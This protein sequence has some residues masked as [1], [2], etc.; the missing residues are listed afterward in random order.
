M[1]MQESARRSHWTACRSRSKLRR[2][3]VLS[4][5][6]RIAI[7]GALILLWLAMLLLGGPGSAADLAVLHAF[8]LPALIPAA[9][10]MTRLGDWDIILPVGLAAA[11]IS[12]LRAAPMRGAVLVLLILSSRL[13]IEGQKSWF[14]R[15]RPDPHGHLVAV[16]S[17]AF[18]S[19]HA[20]NSMILWLGIALIA[21]TDRR[22]RV[23]ALLLGLLLTAGTGLSRLVLAVHWPSDVIGGWC[24]GAVWTLAF[25]R[26]AI[27]GEPAPSEQV[28]PSVI[29]SP[30]GE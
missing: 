14:D 8:R 22:L 13:M 24:F 12:L 2:M 17:M 19:G 9:R 27:A 5:R 21:V 10:L 23:P 18:P 7:M 11:A 6:Y 3:S 25:A 4:D 29:L 16:N 20:A 1:K 28:P 26:L 30:E 15:A